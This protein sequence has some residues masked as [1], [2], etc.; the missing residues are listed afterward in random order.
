MIGRVMRTIFWS[1][2]GASLALSIYYGWQKNIFLMNSFILGA[3]VLFVL[4]LIQKSSF[5]KKYY[6][7]S[8]GNT[9]LGLGGLIF[10]TTSLGTLYFYY[11]VKF[12]EYD[13]I[14]H[15]VIPAS[16]VVMTAMLYEIVKIRKGVPEKIEVILVSSIPV[17]LL[18]FF[19]EF[20]QEQGDI[21]WGTHMFFD[22]NQPI[23]VDV[24]ND[25]V[26]DTFGVF[27]GCV[28]IF[29]NWVGW[30]KKWLKRG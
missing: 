17:L 10:F 16:F 1:A 6:N 7:D 23:V 14:V 21:W 22:S 9:L 8:F 30:N 18:S 4:Y 3:L 28:L 20:F 25:L 29:K 15:V 12:F 2:V 26:A 27:I 19:W 5:V 13:L 11:Y 24:A